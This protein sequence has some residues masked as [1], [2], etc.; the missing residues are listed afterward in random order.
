MTSNFKRS[1]DRRVLLVPVVGLIVSFGGGIYLV[2]LDVIRCLRPATLAELN[3]YT[4]WTR[5]VLSSDLVITWLATLMIIWK[6]YRVGQRSMQMTDRKSN[7]YINI[8]LALVE[9]GILYS[10]V[11]GVFVALSF[12][13][14]VS[15]VVFFVVYC[16]II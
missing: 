16:P 7:K 8:I 12:A 13:S 15:K 3:A 14:L 9:S 5:G 10:V 6:L 11:L 4:R 1:R 2:A